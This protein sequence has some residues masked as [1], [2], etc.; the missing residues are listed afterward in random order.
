MPPRDVKY[1]LL[2][3]SCRQ[4]HLRRNRSRRLPSPDYVLLVVRYPFPFRDVLLHSSIVA[5]L[6]RLDQ[7]GAHR[8]LTLVGRS[9]L[10]RR[11]EFAFVYGVD[12]G[13]G[14]TV[15][16]TGVAEATCVDCVDC[17]DC[18]S[19]TGCGQ[20]WQLR[21]SSG[22][23]KLWKPRAPVRLSLRVS[24]VGQRCRHRVARCEGTWR[25]TRSSKAG[26]G[27]TGRCA[28]PSNPSVV[29]VTAHR[30]ALVSLTCGCRGHWCGPV[31]C[32]SGGDTRTGNR[33][34]SCLA[35]PGRRACGGGD[36]CGGGACGGDG[37]S[38]VSGSIFGTGRGTLR[39]RSGSSS[40]HGISSRTASASAA[41]Y[42]MPR[43]FLR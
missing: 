9:E 36:G 24:L 33:M 7:L 19:Q 14:S 20:R 31:Q 13:G 17:V 12:V 15:R 21:Y 43:C 34:L 42:L 3:A 27:G 30:G 5:A 18:V 6:M 10:C 8:S 25:R 1:L 32:S 41:L 23:H 35:C 26:R 37:G 40:G 38:D 11:T 22:L 28:W 16:V 29:S 39:G 2:S 4:H